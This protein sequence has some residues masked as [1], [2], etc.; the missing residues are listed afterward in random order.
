MHLIR[1]FTIS[2]SK[3]F[4]LFLLRI[5]NSLKNCLWVEY[6]FKNRTLTICKLNRTY[7]TTNQN[8][9]QAVVNRPPKINLSKATDGL[10]AIFFF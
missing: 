1:Y 2:F 5:F 7:Q 9:I 3:Y 8:Q 10:N 4:P 6:L